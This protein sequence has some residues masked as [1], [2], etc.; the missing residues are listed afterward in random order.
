MRR[1]VHAQAV[2]VDSLLEAL[3]ASRV[4]VRQSQATPRRAMTF[5]MPEQRERAAEASPASRRAL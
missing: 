2:A 3:Q 4:L 1:R 5:E